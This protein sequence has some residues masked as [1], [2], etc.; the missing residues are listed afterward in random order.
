[1]HS[2]GCPAYFLWPI[3]NPLITYEKAVASKHVEGRPLVNHNMNN[4]SE[5]ILAPKVTLRII[6]GRNPICSIEYKLVS[7]TK[8]IAMASAATK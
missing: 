5:N 7:K 2:C 8:E 3:F 4:V 6:I 1:M